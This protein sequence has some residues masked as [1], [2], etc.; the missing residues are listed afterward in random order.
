MVPVMFPWSLHHCCQWRLGAR[1]RSTSAAVLFPSLLDAAHRA[2][3]FKY[4]VASWSCSVIPSIPPVCRVLHSWSV[5]DKSERRNILKRNSKRKVS[6]VRSLNCIVQNIGG[7]RIIKQ[8]VLWR[9]AVE[10]IKYSPC[11]P[12]NHKS[13][14]RDPI[15]SLFGTRT[16]SVCSQTVTLHFA[17]SGKTSL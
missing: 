7:Q 5:I 4:K 6:W 14:I 3:V 17:T 16:A 15:K 2:T 13:N 11:V 1:Q 10:G 12:E 9:C 8:D